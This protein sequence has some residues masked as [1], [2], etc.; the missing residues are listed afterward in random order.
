MKLKD[1]MLC[2]ISLVIEFNV[3]SISSPNISLA[4]FKEKTSVKEADL[5]TKSKGQTQNCIFEPQIYSFLFRHFEISFR[6]SRKS[7]ENSAF[8]VVSFKNVISDKW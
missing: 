4:V 2:M 7:F 5:F 6:K 1:M 3:L 8:C